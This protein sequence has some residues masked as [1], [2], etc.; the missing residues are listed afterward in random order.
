MRRA[1]Q[2][3]NENC[4]H[5]FKTLEMY[6]DTAPLLSP[7]V[8]KKDN[9]I[10]P[11]SREKLLRSI[12]TAVHKSRRGAVPIDEFVGDIE[13]MVNANINPTDTKT[14]GEQ[15]MNY[16]RRH[17]EIA[18]LRYASVYKEMH[19]ANDFRALLGEKEGEK[20]DEKE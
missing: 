8:R 17:D 15:A 1:R 10:A 12:N 19:S 6:A 13:A 14:I 5:K 11:F 16:L 2:C 9:T 4:K 18:F 7:Y 3:K 20:L